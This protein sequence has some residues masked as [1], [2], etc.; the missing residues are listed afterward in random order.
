MEMLFCTTYI[1]YHNFLCPDGTSG[2]NRNLL[3]MDDITTSTG[4]GRGVGGGVKVEYTDV[5]IGN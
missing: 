2:T 4:L 3:Q 5:G 1:F